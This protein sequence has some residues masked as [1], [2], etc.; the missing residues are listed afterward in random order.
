MTK[1]LIEHIFCSIFVFFT[2]VD[3]GLF[4][5]NGVYGPTI[6]GKKGGLKEFLEGWSCN[7]AVLR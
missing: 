3:S 5:S 1:N 6:L 7:I 2:L 4:S